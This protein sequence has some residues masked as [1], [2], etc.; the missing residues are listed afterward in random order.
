M[1]ESLFFKP[2]ACNFIN[3][4]TVAQFFFCEFC[5]ILKK[6]FLQNTYR[7][8]LLYLIFLTSCWQFSDI[9]ICFTSSPGQHLSENL[10]PLSKF[11]ILKNASI[12]YIKVNIKW[13][14]VI[15][16]SNQKYS[17]TNNYFLI[18]FF[19]RSL[20]THFSSVLHVT[21]KPV[22]W[23]GL[24]I[25]WLVSIWNATLDWTGLI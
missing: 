5:D 11:W 3:K 18:T 22:I 8:L 1:S 9:H 25:K 17:L 19:F 6:P 13:L 7:Q 14:L 10:Q 16:V 4:E 2:K 23:F 12:T 24:Q 21:Q 15:F 20:K